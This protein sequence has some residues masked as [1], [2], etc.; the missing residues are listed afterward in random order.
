MLFEH[1]FTTL[2]THQFMSNDLLKIMVKATAG[3]GSGS[4]SAKTT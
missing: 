3:G 4:L 1:L 2:I